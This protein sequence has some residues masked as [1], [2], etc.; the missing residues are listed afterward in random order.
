MRLTPE[1]K[2]WS[3]GYGASRPRRSAHGSTLNVAPRRRDAVAG[4]GQLR[5]TVHGEHNGMETRLMVG[6]RGLSTEAP[7][8]T[9]LFGL[10]H[11]QYV[12]SFDFLVVYCL[13]MLLD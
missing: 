8:Q 1:G 6:Y 2:W 13:A 7:T 4:G 12:F 11:G 10:G 5:E 3:R 9:A